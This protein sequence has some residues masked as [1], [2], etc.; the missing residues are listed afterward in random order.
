MKIEILSDVMISGEPAVAG[1]LVEV[2][3]ADANLLIG[4][5]K[6]KPPS[7]D[8]SEPES[9]A[10]L[11]GDAAE[12]EAEAPQLTDAPKRGRKPVPTTEV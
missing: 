1:S 4:M 2:S 12:T 7:D 6:A 3:I 9:E 5:N 10:P 8:A 11:I